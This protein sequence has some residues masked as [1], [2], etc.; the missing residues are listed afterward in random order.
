LNGIHQFLA[1]FD[2]V[3]LL[4]DNMITRKDTETLIDAGKEIS[5]EIKAEETKNMLLFR[6]PNIGQIRVI[7][8]ANILFENVSQFKDFGTTVTNRNLILE[9]GLNSGNACYHSVQKFCLLVCCR[10]T[11]RL[12]YI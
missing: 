5:P 9:E 4:G 8:I 11:K 6:H 12:K 1:D 7:E 3:D 2:D 10:R